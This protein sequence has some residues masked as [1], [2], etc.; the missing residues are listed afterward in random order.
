MIF[1][2]TYVLNGR[3][4]WAFEVQAYRET[5]RA[6]HVLGVPEERI[7]AYIDGR[8]ERIW[9]AYTLIRIACRK[10]DVLRYTPEI[11]HED[12][13]RFRGAA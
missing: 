12:Y 9:K 2:G 10:K 3:M 1:A 4:G 7:Q 5:M 8:A 11:L 13:D 6:L